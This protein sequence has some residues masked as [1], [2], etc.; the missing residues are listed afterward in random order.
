MTIELSI[1]IPIYNEALRIDVCMQKILRYRTA[2]F[3]DTVEIIM[4]EN[5]STDHTIQAAEPYTGFKNVHLHSLKTRGK[6]YAVKYG[7]LQARGRWRM[8]ADCDWSMPTSEITKFMLRR[9][10]RTI[11]IGDR[12]HVSSHV[13][14]SIIRAVLGKGINLFVQYAALPGIWDSQCGFKMFPADVAIDLFSAQTLTGMSFDIELL[15]IARLRG[16]KILSVP[17]TWVA[18]RD[19]RVKITDGIDTIRD[20]LQIKK[21]A[22]NG[23]YRELKWL[24]D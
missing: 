14:Q 23:M 3:A 16:Y 22:Q 5:G 8:M 1:I 11:L 6:G 21:A 10:P 20:I 15:Y 19:T 18:D 24:A 4:V 2:E 12:A 9:E 7:M 13:K 17:I